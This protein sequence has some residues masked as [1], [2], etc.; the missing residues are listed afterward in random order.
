MRSRLTGGCI[1]GDKRV[2]TRCRGITSTR[3]ATAVIGDRRAIHY[4]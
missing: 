3:T 2:A 4:V 1:R